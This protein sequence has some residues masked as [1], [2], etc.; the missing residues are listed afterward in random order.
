[1][2]EPITHL[3]V[4]SEGD[5]R[6]V[7]LFSGA[8]ESTDWLRNVDGET[9]L[10]GDWH[11]LPE[12]TLFAVGEIASQGLWR[13]E[14]AGT[15][16]N[17]RAWRWRLFSL[18]QRLA[19]QAGHQADRRAEADHCL[20]AADQLQLLA[21]ENNKHESESSIQLAEQA[22][23]WQLQAAQALVQLWDSNQEPSSAMAV[24]LELMHLFDALS[25]GDGT[26]LGENGLANAERNAI[27]WWRQAVQKAAQCSD[28]QE[29]QGELSIAAA[30]ADTVLDLA[31]HRLAARSMAAS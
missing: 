16:I 26:G 20:K 9:V 24:A 13:Q 19:A 4:F 1:M 3:K 31:A 28:E 18:H 6:Q 27:F 8:N 21:H 7:A 22:T 29:Q 10:T 17:P 5:R 30:A 2:A 14:S 25:Q 11:Q 23:G 15:P 12:E